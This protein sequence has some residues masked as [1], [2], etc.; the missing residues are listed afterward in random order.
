M[1]FFEFL[2][3]NWTELFALTREHLL[4]VL[5]STAFAVLIGV[6]SAFY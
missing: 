1:N 3:Q 5:V 2:Q 6:P 4:L